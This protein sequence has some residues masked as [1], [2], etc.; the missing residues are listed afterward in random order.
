VVCRLLYGWE[1]QE[2]LFSQTMHGTR[3]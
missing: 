1:R 3:C 2:L